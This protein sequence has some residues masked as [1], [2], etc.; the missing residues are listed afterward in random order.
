MC[1]SLLSNTIY[2]INVFFYYLKKKHVMYLIKCSIK[3]ITETYVLPCLFY[4]FVY[5]SVYRKILQ[6]YVIQKKHT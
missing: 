4:K 6:I 2:S 1:I 5:K 3:F